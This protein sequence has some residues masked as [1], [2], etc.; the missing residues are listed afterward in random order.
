MNAFTF[1]T[2]GGNPAAVVYLPK[3]R[4]DAWH[5]SIAREFNISETAFIIR[6]RVASPS[7]EQSPSAKQK[8][9]GAKS[10][11][12]EAESSG[13]GLK[14]VKKIAPKKPIYDFDLRWFTPEAEVD[15]CGHAT[16]ASAH[17]LFATGLVPA[18][19]TITF[20]TRSGPL[21][22]KKIELEDSYFAP[23]FNSEKNGKSSPTSSQGKPKAGAIYSLDFPIDEFTSEIGEE[24]ISSLK[25]ALTGVNIIWAGRTSLQNVIVCLVI[26]L[27][28]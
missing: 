3:Q 13:E 23:L 11:L 16:L 12:I 9:F 5:L 20:H 4:D 2:F 17:F 27:I 21:M 7:S 28:S 14:S 18:E 10:P 22:S 1:S 26:S 19:E 6:R 8:G 15:L 24:E 25:E